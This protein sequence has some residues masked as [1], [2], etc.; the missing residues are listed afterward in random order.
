[1]KIAAAATTIGATLRG[2][3]VVDAK[4]Q[5]EELRVLQ[6]GMAHWIGLFLLESRVAV[7]DGVPALDSR[8]L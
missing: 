8:A 6:Q 3:L 7:F 2:E 4:K 1:M 5:G